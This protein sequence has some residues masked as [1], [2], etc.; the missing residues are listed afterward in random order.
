LTRASIKSVQEETA[1]LRT[2]L[3]G[4]RC[5]LRGQSIRERI[6]NSDWHAHRT[7]GELPAGRLFEFN[8]V[9]KGGSKQR[10]GDQRRR[11]SARGGNEKRSDKLLPLRRMQTQTVLLAPNPQMGRK[12]TNTQRWRWYKTTHAHGR[13]CPS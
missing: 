13:E 2:H 1:R 4:A 11:F 6:L 7:A 12:H 10:E 8:T 5:P 3:S 9:G